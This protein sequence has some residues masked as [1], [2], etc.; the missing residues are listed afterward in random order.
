M[1]NPNV[2]D[3]KSWRLAAEQGD[4]DAQN[5]L[6]IAYSKGEGVT[7]DY[8]EAVKWYRKAAD[9]GDADAQFN[10]G[11]A[12]CVSKGVPENADRRQRMLNR[13]L[14]PDEGYIRAEKERRWVAYGLGG[15]VPQ[16]YVEGHKWLNLA[17]AAGHTEAGETRELVEKEMTP[18]QIAEAQRLAREWKPTK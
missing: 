3:V 2:E 7:Q 6:G 12:Y 11:N 4:A 1:S 14:Y 5:K 13:R 17:A 15:R 8:A 18:E 9:Q 16:D 10:L